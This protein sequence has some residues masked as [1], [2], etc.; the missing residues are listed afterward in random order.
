MIRVRITE[1]TTTDDPYCVVESLDGSK[2]GEFFGSIEDFRA[3][4]P[5]IEIVEEVWS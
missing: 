5:S 4:N 1:H 3:E 2:S